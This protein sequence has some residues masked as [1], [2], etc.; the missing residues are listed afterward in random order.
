MGRMVLVTGGSRSGKSSYAQKAVEALNTSRL[1]IATCPVIDEEMKERIQKHQ[2]DRVGRGWHTIEEPVNI[3]GV[4][5]NAQAFAAVLVDCLTLWINNL[6]YVAE[7]AGKNISET[8][9]AEECEKLSAA[10]KRHPGTI[11]LVTN[12][13][14]MGII[15]ENTSARLYRDLVGRCNQMIANASHQA[16]LLVSGQPM[17]IK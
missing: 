13:I 17:I 1:Y 2:Q 9:V 8:D 6:M 11:F 3:T 14:G 4:I 15:P 16:V 10:C 5:E 7:N 12:E